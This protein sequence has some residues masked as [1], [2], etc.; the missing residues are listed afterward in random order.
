MPLVEA[1]I[2]FDFLQGPLM[3]IEL[4][5]VGVV[6]PRKANGGGGPVVV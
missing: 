4:L 3:S 2:V 1:D 6:P 5:G